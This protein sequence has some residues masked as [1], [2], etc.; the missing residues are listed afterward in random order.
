MQTVGIWMRTQSTQVSTAAV[1]TPSCQQGGMYQ[2]K[3]LGLG[4]LNSWYVHPL[5]IPLLRL[6]I[7]F[8]MVLLALGDLTVATTLYCLMLEVSWHQAYPYLLKCQIGSM[9][10]CGTLTSPNLLAKMLVVCILIRSSSV[11]RL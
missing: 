6:S 5:A 2:A 8:L 9:P 1:A 11:L 7:L 3:D 10:K 4:L